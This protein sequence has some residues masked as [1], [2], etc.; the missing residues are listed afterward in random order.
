MA[1]PIPIAIYGRDGKIV[2]AIRELLLPDIDVVHTSLTLPTA[3]TELP[4]LLSG[5][6][7]TAPSSGLGS[8]ASR[9]ESERLVP[10]A[11]FF[12][13]GVP[14]E[15]V[16]LVQRLVLEKLGEG[17]GD[18]KEGGPKFLRVTREEVLAA[19]AK[20]PDPGVIAGIYRRKVE[21]L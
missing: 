10:K 2:E 11:V 15:E 21:G 7:S 3:S 17:E 1:A 12:G 19:G 4:L 6:L 8:N 16:E 9:A 14:E 20:G 13:G 18:G 5:A